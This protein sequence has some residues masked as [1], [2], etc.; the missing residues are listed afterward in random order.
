MKNANF[1]LGR[2][3]VKFIGFR[4]IFGRSKSFFGLFSW[5]LLPSG[6]VRDSFGMEYEGRDY[7][8]WRWTLRHKGQDFVHKG[9]DF[10][11]KGQDF[12]PHDSKNVPNEQ[13]IR[14]M[15]LVGSEPKEV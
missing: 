9:Q 8:T 7:T 1:V 2:N 14:H 6:W 5:L 11:H 4:C 13:Q 10:V 12:V 3:T 15:T